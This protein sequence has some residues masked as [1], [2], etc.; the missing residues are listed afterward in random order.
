[1][2]HHESAPKVLGFRAVISSTF[3]YLHVFFL[4][5]RRIVSLRLILRQRVDNEVIKLSRSQ[6]SMTKC[7]ARNKPHRQRLY[8]T[9]MGADQLPFVSVLADVG[10]EGI[11]FTTQSKIHSIRIASIR[12]KI[13]FRQN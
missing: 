2:T 9:L 1:M 7:L 11:S 3:L 5:R 13:L 12:G 6:R 10:S 4:C 8:F